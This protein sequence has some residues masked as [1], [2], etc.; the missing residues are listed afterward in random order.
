MRTVSALRVALK[1]A[2][3]LG[4][5]QVGLH[6]RV[7]TPFLSASALCPSPFTRLAT[8]CS[9]TS[10]DAQSAASNGDA[11]DSTSSS[12]NNDNNNNGEGKA[13]ATQDPQK[14]HDAL[15]AK[16]TKEVKDLKDQIVRSYAEEE[17]VRRIAK[18]DVET[19]RQYGNVSFAKH[20]LDV[21]DNLERAIEAVPAA[22]R[23]DLRAGK[24]D[25]NLKMLLEGIEAT[26]RGLQKAFQ[27]NGV[28]RFG[29]A[30]DSFDPALH[31]A[32]YSAPKEGAQVGTIAQVL[33]AGYRLRDRVIRPAQVGT[34][35][36]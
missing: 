30:G 19:A 33:K 32:L 24:G 8:R 15:V 11:S 21:A 10:A 36:A 22:V 34:V 25:A 27:Q 17:N 5:R 6:G 13:E 31:D 7:A 4:Q 1:A 35:S 18:K 28:V 23:E 12:S 9:S 26:E 3:S 29:G 14:E 20:M 16:L 2:G